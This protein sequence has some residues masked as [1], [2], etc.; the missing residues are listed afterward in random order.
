MTQSALPAFPCLQCRLG[1]VNPSPMPATS[2]WSALLV[3][4]IYTNRPSHTRL[5]STHA[6]YTNVSDHLPIVSD[7]S[8]SV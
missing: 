5:L 7:M 3:D 2:A 6:F 1:A 8:F 4:Y